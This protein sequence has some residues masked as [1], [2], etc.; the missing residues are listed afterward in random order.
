M[1]LSVQIMQCTNI[2]MTQLFID[3]I[4]P[5]IKQKSNITLI[6]YITKNMYIQKTKS[7]QNDH[8]SLFIELKNHYN[9]PLHINCSVLRHFQ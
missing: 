6:Y 4:G 2:L 5:V 7:H 3:L 1:A 8:K 9:V